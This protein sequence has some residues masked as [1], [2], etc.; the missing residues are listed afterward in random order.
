[1]FPPGKGVE[2]FTITS[3]GEHAYIGDTIDAALQAACKAK[4]SC[5]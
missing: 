4:A 2:V 1:V 3:D 5:K